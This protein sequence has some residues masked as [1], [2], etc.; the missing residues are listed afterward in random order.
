M[1]HSATQG[2]CPKSRVG[3]K[4]GGNPDSAWVTVRCSSTPWIKSPELRNRGEAWRGKWERAGFEEDYQQWQT[5]PSNFGSSNSWRKI[6]PMTMK[7]ETQKKR[8]PWAI[9]FITAWCEMLATSSWFVA[10]STGLLE[11][12]NKEQGTRKKAAVCMSITPESRR[13][14]LGGSA[15]PWASIHCPIYCLLRF[16][17]CLLYYLVLIFYNYLCVVY[18]GSSTWFDPDWLG[19]PSLIPNYL[20]RPKFLDTLGP[21]LQPSQPKFLELLFFKR[22]IQ[23]G[24]PPL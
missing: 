18:H 17:F 24:R 7:L 9:N 16:F 13:V 21:N 8:T 22:K 4:Q 20:V 10:S 23:Q 12:R 15:A 3:V 6:K 2:H 14:T 5:G 11:K 19:S 1:E